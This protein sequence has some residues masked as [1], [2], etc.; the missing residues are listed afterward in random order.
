MPREDK[1][2]AL[3]F[4]VIPITALGAMIYGGYLLY[5][6]AKDRAEKQCQTIGAT[7]VVGWMCVKPDGTLWL[8]PND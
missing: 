2:F 1:I 5:G 3:I 4:S 6:Q 7:H 8:R